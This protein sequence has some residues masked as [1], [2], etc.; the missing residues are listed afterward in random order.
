MLALLL[1][2]GAGLSLLR[3]AL[4]LLLLLLLLVAAC[5]GGAGASQAPVATNTVD[6]PPSYRFAPAAIT[7]TVGTTVT[8]TNHDN[9]T[10]NVTLPRVAPLTMHPGETVSHNFDTAGS[11]AYVC[12]LHPKDMNGT[13]LVE[14]G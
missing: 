9:F 2:A 3:P 8:W 1:R 13:V 10:H 11:F 5:S 4:A 7:V 12:S 6:L 14:G